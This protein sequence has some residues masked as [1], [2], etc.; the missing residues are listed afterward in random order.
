M[1]LITNRKVLV[2]KILELLMR[3]LPTFDRD[4]ATIATDRMNIG[5]GPNALHGWYNIDNSPTAWLAK[6]PRFYKFLSDLH[7]ITNQHNV[8]DWASN[9]VVHDIRRGLPC[10]S[11]SIRYI[12]SSHVLEHLYRKEARFVLH[13]CHRVLKP[14][15]GDSNCCTRP[16]PLH[17]SIPR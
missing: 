10:P 7:L 6:R 9:I 8:Y 14:G 4:V 17:T 11:S 3:Y 12:Y 1:E 5:C 15:G 13:E 16:S 2:W